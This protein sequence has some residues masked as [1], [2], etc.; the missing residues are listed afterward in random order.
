MKNS[1]M[2]L[3]I[4]VALVAMVSC[5]KQT[6]VVES[7][8]YQGTIQKVEP[9]KTEIYVELTDGRV[10]ELYFTDQTTLTQNGESV[11]FSALAKGQTIEVKVEKVGKRLDPISVE[12]KE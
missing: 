10:I 5:G 1:L 6:A 7:G 8:T 12:I 4:L 9:E 2:V 3:V 11:E